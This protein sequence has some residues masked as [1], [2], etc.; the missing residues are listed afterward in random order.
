MS[1]HD[2]PEFRFS[3]SSM[4]FSLTALSFCGKVCPNSVNADS[5]LAVAERG[6]TSRARATADLTGVSVVAA[7]S[8]KGHNGM[9]VL[10]AGGEYRVDPVCAMTRRFIYAVLISAAAAAPGFA[11]T[12]ATPYSVTNRGVVALGTNNT[13]ALTP[14]TTGVTANP[15]A[16]AQSTS[17]TTT[18]TTGTAL[19]PTPGTATGAASGA[20]N[21][22][23]LSS[24]SRSSMSRPSASRAASPASSAGSP[25]SAT[26]TASSNVPTWLLCPPSGA[27]GMEPFVA[28]TSLSCAP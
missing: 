2:V 18:G 20:G 8:K 25:G 9:L 14:T 10:E 23:T 13:T 4:S 17:A 15:A 11:Q 3:R 5:T 22:S 26:G 7:N 12:T 24:T 28:G 19:G 27:S 6:G 16:P 21:A 1:D